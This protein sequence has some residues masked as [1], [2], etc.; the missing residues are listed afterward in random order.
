MRLVDSGA[1]GDLLRRVAGRSRLEV[2]RELAGEFDRLDLAGIPGL[3]VRELLTFHTLTGRVRTDPDRWSSL[4]ASSKAIAHGADWRSVLTALG[5]QIERRPNRGIVEEHNRLS[6]SRAMGRASG[7]RN[8]S[9]STSCADPTV[10]LPPDAD[11]AEEALT[12]ERSSTVR[13]A[14]STI[15]ASSATGSSPMTTRR[16]RSYKSSRPL[17]Y[18]RCS[19]PHA[20]NRSRRTTSA[21]CA[22]WQCCHLRLL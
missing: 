18:S 16:S 8:D 9:R 17:A 10:L 20:A 15:R 6:D 11:R 4:E 13:H 5:Y 19:R 22:G 1:L 3:K 7:R 21:S 14:L 12:F 2:V